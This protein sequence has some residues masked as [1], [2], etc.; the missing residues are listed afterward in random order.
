MGSRIEISKRL[1]LLN[2]SSA[3]LAR[4][5]NVLVIV[6]LHQYLLR[7]ISPAE[8]Q[9]LPVL[10]SIILL[11][12]LFTG[13][14]TSGIGRFVL[15]AYA[16]GDD[17]G[18]TQIV[19]TMFPLLT[20]AGG[21]ILAAGLLLTWHLDKVL[22]VPLAQLRDARVMMTLLVFSAALRPPTAAFTVGFY[23]RQKFVLHNAINMGSELLRVSLLFLL[24]FGIGPRVLW[25]VVSSVAAEWAALV[26]LLILSRRMI[27]ALRFRMREI[28]WARARELASFGGW[29]T[30]GVVAY[31][32]RETVIFTILNWFATPLDVT[33]F[34]VGYLGRRQIDAWTDV[35]AG[36]LYPVVTG[37]HALGAKDRIRNIYLRG[38]RLALWFTLLAGLPAALYAP[39]IIHLYIGTAFQDAAF[40]MIVSLA[41]L[42]IGGGGWM[43]WQVSNA[44]GRVRAISL[45]IV[46]MQVATVALACYAVYVLGW[47]A[48]GVA[49]AVFLAGTVSEC[50]LLLPLGLKLAD[51]TFAAWV[52]HTL[53]PGLTPGAVA[54]V[55]W[56]A[57]GLLVRPDSWIL[58]GLC[59]LA[60]MVCYLVVLLAFC[61][62][63][64]DREDLAEVGVRVAT[65]LR[66]YF[67]APPSPASSTPSPQPVPAQLPTE[68]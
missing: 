20:A 13:I 31:R 44:T 18:V 65:R 24:L 36:P 29:H 21:A 66:Q 63:P 23:A 3:V 22:S 48:I 34:H 30:L 43:I 51:V 56:A 2:T 32:A 15:A 38:G 54:A 6:W 41:G 17:R 40:I 61:L 49:W 12:P 37:M 67:G 26:V 57:L 58:V 47:G 25:V 50:L 64:N 53:L 27:P 19:S 52:R 42:V 11:L 68:G 10:T 59:T 5:I 55:V 8:Y 16:R 46:V 33:V 9:L 14:L 45:S 1:V 28:H 4:T 7:R 39:T 35:M 60:G 62:E